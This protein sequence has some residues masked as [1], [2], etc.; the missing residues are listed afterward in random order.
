MDYNLLADLVLPGVGKTPEYYFKLYPKRNLPSGVQ[1]TRYAP[2]P[3]GFQHIG[4]IFSSLTAER[5][6]HLSG[7]VF[8]L[9]IED[10]DKK[11]EVEGAIEDTIKTLEYF[12]IVFDEGMMDSGHEKGSYGP[13]KQSE[14]KEIYQTFVK[15]LVAK[16]LAYP[17]FCTEEELDEIR[18]KQAEV[19][20]N[21]G[22]YGEWTRCRNLTLE[23]VKDRIDSG[24]PFI[25]RL[26]SPGDSNRR[27][28]LNDLIR[29]EISF[30]ENDQDVVIMKSDG[31][32][33]YHFA[34]AVDDYLM[35]TT[36]VIRSEEWLPSVPI[37]LQLFD[38]LGFDKP[39]FAHIPQ[40]MKLDGSSKRKLSKRKDPE[41]AV[42]YFITQGYPPQSVIEYLINLMNSGFEVWRNENPEVPY[43]GFEVKLDRMS[44]SGALFD[45]VKLNN[46]ST[47]VIASFQAEKVYELY[48]EWA[49]K[50]DEE[51]AELLT[52]NPN[53]VKKIF[54][55]D[56]EGPKPRKDI[57]K[58]ADVREYIGYYFDNVFKEIIREGYN[59]PERVSY[60]EAKALLKEYTKIY[61]PSDDKD[62]WF[63]KIK[64]LASNMGYASDNK[65]FK[66]NPELYKGNVADVA[67]VIRAAMTNKANTP[68]LY[69]IMQIMGRERVLGRLSI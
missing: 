68:D 3:T 17:C 46:I 12:G 62:T 41:A 63:S 64:E 42:E 32:P 49:E 5:M 23:E 27:V 4:G 16:G 22:Y 10:T 6:A 25:I 7:G 36:I 19:K 39:E 34:H 56:R 47:N 24:I 29:G 35:G 1:V 26:K 20:A 52:Q 53:Y 30:P 33:T 8:Y 13:Y 31:L 51:M 14:R 66:K 55:I 59:L 21:P 11:R 2:S 54:N 61:D 69:E 45:L 28:V 58:W 40:V 43:T 65:A 37:H 50:Y 60:E 48:L 67:A 9:R 15:S 18:R 38:V 44:E 57:G